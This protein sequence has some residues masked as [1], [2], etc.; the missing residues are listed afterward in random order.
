[1]FMQEITLF[2]KYDTTHLYMLEI[3]LQPCQILLW[4]LLYKDLGHIKTDLNIKQNLN[5]I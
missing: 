1:M 5:V 4:V 2:Y 3:V